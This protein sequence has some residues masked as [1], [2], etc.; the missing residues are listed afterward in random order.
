MRISRVFR[1]VCFATL[2]PLLVAVPSRSQQP[3]SPSPEPSDPKALM[4]ASRKLNNLAASDVKPWHIK[5]TFELFDQQGTV[6]EDGTYEEFWASPFQFKRTFT[7]KNFTQTAYGS[8]NGVLLANTK[9][10]TPQLLLDAR[11]NL[12]SPMPFFEAII[13]NTTYTTKTLNSGNLK[14]LCAIPT[15]ALHGGPVDNSAYCFNTDEPMLRIAARPSTSD[16]TFH[17]RL[18]RIED[19]VIASD[20]KITHDGK[21]TVALHVQEASALDPSE[22][23]VFTP[24]PD[25]VLEP[26]RVNVSGAI[27]AGMLEYKVAPEY[28]EAAH[29]AHISGTIVLAAIIGKD[30]KLRDLKAISGPE[31]LQGAAIQAVHQWRYRPY[32]LNGQPVEM[33]TTINVIFKLP[34]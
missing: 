23:A 13:Q 3:A 12:V 8:K 5:G 34:S 1:A 14:L 29:I 33:R 32:L 11:N 16:Q 19:C 9:G 2:L 27:A 21:I 7:G 18:I 20:L 25:A 30:G 10:D 17:N 15:A 26:R 24:P 31:A 22:Q 6:S 4:L 28:P